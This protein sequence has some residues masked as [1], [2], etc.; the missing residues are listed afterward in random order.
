MQA[1]EQ[2][3]QLAGMGHVETHA[4]VTQVKGL[5]LRVKAQHQL[6]PRLVA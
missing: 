5:P 6:G 4:V 3:E 2:A 1:L